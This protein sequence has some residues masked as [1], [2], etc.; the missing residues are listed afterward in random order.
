MMV[1]LSEMK[2][3]FIILPGEF[4]ANRESL[5]E[6]IVDR[7]NLA[8]Y[9]RSNEIIVL[10]G[11][12][13]CGTTH[14]LKYLK[15]FLDE[16]NAI[17]TYITTPVESSLRSLYSEF[18]HQIRSDR[19][20]AVISRIID[21]LLEQA[22]QDER[23]VSE[24]ELM[25]H[26]PALRAIIYGESTRTMSLRE[27]S[28]LRKIAR[29]PTTFEL[30]SRMIA[31]LSTESWPVFV[32]LDEFDAALLGSS[33]MELLY[34]LRRLFDETLT[35]L[36]LVIGLKGKPKD[37]EEKLG[38]A[39]YSRMTFQPIHL[40]PLSKIEGL[41]FLKAILQQAGTRL[42]KKPTSLHFP[43]IEKSLKTLIELTCPTTPRR[44]LRTSS[45]IF[46]EA[47][48]ERLSRIDEDFVLK[49]AMKFGEVSTIIPE[50]EAKPL[51][52]KEE[53][54]EIPKAIPKAPETLQ[55]IIQ[56]GRN[57]QPNLA[58]DPRELTT[59]EVVGLILYA[60]KPTSLTLS[61]IKELVS[62][63]WKSLSIYSTSAA[64]GKMRGLIIREGK[65]GSYHY[66]LSGMG[67]SWIENE[68][69]PR[70]KGKTK[71]EKK[72]RRGG[73][74]KAL[75]SPKIDEL[76]EENFFKLPNKRKVPEVVKALG[77]KGLPTTGKEKAVLA[78]LKRR[79]GKTL[80]GTKEGK[81]WVFWTD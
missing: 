30:W 38:R 75:Y 41:E 53:R 32:L 2:N 46:E 31:D 14:T 27:R 6:R 58:V 22:S 56:F 17:A 8:R 77:E 15:K 74:R 72:E 9:T 1:E 50:L 18:V 42:K 76:I 43:F 3:P 59:K 45:L 48:S 20:E 69:I 7:I 29:I 54:E 36:C 16:K 79:L 71:E 81:E 39:L 47:K 23:P 40:Y 66:R 52:V 37:A 5:W 57:G 19:R 11:P 65:R 12:Y 24:A 73:P 63:N 4:W 60:K 80:N 33:S 55:G 78:A 10:T 34:D 49:I 21:D 28:F 35:G 13:G 62:R 70:L 51:K 64:I 61:E 25:E 68:L 44:L 67:E 26:I